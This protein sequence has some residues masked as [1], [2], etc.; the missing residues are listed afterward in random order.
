MLAEP[1]TTETNAPTDADERDHATAARRAVAA[2]GAATP[3]K[4]NRQAEVHR[5]EVEVLGLI[6]M[7]ARSPALG[8]LVYKG[9]SLKEEAE[10]LWVPYGAADERE[11]DLRAAGAPEEEIAAARLDERATWAAW[12]DKRQEIEEAAFEVANAPFGGLHDLLARAQAAA[13]LIGANGDEEGLPEN[14][15]DV[16]VILRS[17]RAGIEEMIARGP[18]REAWDETIIALRDN[19]KA[20][21]SANQEW[22]DAG[23]LD[24]NPADR[25]ELSARIDRLH[26]ARDEYRTKLFSLDPPDVEGLLHLME[27]VFDHGASLDVGTYERRATMIGDRPVLEDEQWQDKDDSHRRA[28][29]L[30]ASHAA[31]LRDLEKPRDW[32]EA[33]RDIGGLHPNAKDAVHLAYE[34]ALDLADL[35]N[36]QLAGQPEE[37]LPTLLFAGQQGQFWARPNSVWKGHMLARDGSL[38]M[39]ADGGEMVK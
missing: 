37:N 16:L 1:Q 9:L 33:M 27:I 34:A 39:A 31:R 7:T 21:S 36:I 25:P 24:F 38:V 8:R 19:E 4:P 6:A 28:F 2:A 14:D 13:L 29:A 35:K 26:S 5:K 12:N 22:E 3:A 32:R 11:R 15:E 23:G 18:D 10:A 20:L 30:L 17:Y